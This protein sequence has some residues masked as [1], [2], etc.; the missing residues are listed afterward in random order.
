[1]KISFRQVEKEDLA[2]LRD[3]RNQD[4]LR[5]L[6]REYRLLNMVNQERWLE[7]I[8]LSRSDD[9]FMVLLDGKPVGICGLTHINWKDRSAEVSYHLGVT[10][11]PAQNVAIGIDVYEFLKKKGFGE[12]NLHRLL[13]EAFAYNPGGIKLAEKCG[14]KQEGV[15]RETV[16]CDGKYWDSVIV[17]MLADE[18]FSRKG[19]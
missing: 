19:K 16:F 4:R 14:F 18:Y 2:L 8:S 13:G 3:W 9:M 7:R 12:Y 1:M 6:F 11:S 10:S 17:G 15:L 5:R